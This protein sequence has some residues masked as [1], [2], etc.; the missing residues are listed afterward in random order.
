M[1][2]L[3]LRIVTISGDKRNKV[4]MKYRGAFNLICELNT[5]KCRSITVG[6]YL[7]D[8]KDIAKKITCKRCKGHFDGTISEQNRKNAGRKTSHP[9]NKTRYG[10]GNIRGSSEGGSGSSGEL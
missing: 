3:Q 10:N 5:D 4:H 1:R 6:G 9:W 2:E 7:R 8:K